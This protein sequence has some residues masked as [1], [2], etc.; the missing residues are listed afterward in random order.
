[1]RIL[2]GT[3]GPELALQLSAL[4]DYRCYDPAEPIV[5]VR[6]AAVANPVVVVCSCVTF[7][8]HIRAVLDHEL[9]L[10]KSAVVVIPSRVAGVGA[11]RAAQKRRAVKVAFL[12]AQP[13]VV[14]KTH[15]RILV[16]PT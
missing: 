4:I 11:I 7:M 14:V 3:M 2:W 15:P 6:E 1:M 12:T 13:P 8:E 16:C 9:C 5:E 10:A